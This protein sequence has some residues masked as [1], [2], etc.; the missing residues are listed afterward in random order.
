MLPE[1]SRYT[2]TRPPEGTVLRHATGPAC[3]SGSAYA[4]FHSWSF[5]VTFYA[6]VVL[7]KETNLPINIINVIFKVQFVS[8]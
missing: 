8:I 1:T 7:I 6:Q 2:C 5:I 3:S 4:D